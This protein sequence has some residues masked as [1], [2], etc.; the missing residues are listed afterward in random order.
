MVCID[1]VIEIRYGRPHIVVGRIAIQ[2]E[3]ECIYVV[4]CQ[5]ALEVE[6]VS[7]KLIFLKLNLYKIV[8]VDF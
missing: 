8:I 5:H 2:I 6:V 7:T 4:Q 1:S 3:E